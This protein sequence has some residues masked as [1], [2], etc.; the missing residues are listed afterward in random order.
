MADEKIIYVE[1]ASKFPAEA[2]PMQSEPNDDLNVATGD[3]LNVAG[4]DFVEF[5]NY[6]R[7]RGVVRKE[8]SFGAE[9]DKTSDRT[10]FVTLYLQPDAEVVS[11]AQELSKRDDVIHAIEARKL[12]PSAPPGGDPLSEP[13]V[14]PRLG[15]IVHANPQTQIDDNQW[16]LFRC[17]VDQAWAQGVSGSGSIVADIDWGFLTSHQEFE[18]RIAFELNTL[19]GGGTVNGGSAIDHGTAVL[20]IVGAGNN[21]LGMIGIAFNAELWLVQAGEDATGKLDPA[22]WWRALQE[23][24]N[25]DGVNKRKVILLEVQTEFHESIDIIPAVKEVINEAISKGIVVCVPA[26]NGSRD[27]GLDVHLR[28]FPAS[29]AILVGATAYDDA[30]NPISGRSNYGMRVPIY[31]PGDESHDLTCSSNGDDKYRSD[32]GGT[33]GAAPKVAGTIALMLEA[34]PGLCHY[35]IKDILKQTG[36]SVTGDPTQVKGSFLN[37]GA[38]VAEARRRAMI[39]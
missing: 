19:N 10:R 2:L 17:R 37:A 26:G 6:L 30:D 24:M 13:F 31:A 5:N 36:T 7:Q 8:F 11:L 23:V 14:R 25:K 4:I 33:S 39:P 18:N 38:A 21:G 28:P 9:T 27:A 1:F 15:G 35:E 34:N 22:P 16:Y 29:G 20:G 3:D 32:F 12:V